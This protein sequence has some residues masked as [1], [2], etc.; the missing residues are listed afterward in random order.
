MGKSIPTK[1]HLRAHSAAGALLQAHIF[2]RS[3]L[4]ELGASCS[5]DRYFALG[6]QRGRCMVAA[7]GSRNARSG[8]MTGAGGRW[9]N[10]ER[11]RMRLLV[12]CQRPITACASLEREENLLLRVLVTKLC[13]EISASTSLIRRTEQKRTFRNGWRTGIGSPPESRHS[14]LRPLQPSS[15]VWG[16]RRSGFRG[17]SIHTEDWTR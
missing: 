11:G 12:F 6:Q 15:A 1:S 2:Q 13:S 14:A 17:S 10:D 4:L 3:A 5:P 9:S 7:M 8:S 16:H